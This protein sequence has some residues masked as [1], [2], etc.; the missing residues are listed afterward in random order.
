MLA[1]LLGEGLADDMV[2][3]TRR[4][5]SWQGS[6][7]FAAHNQGSPAFMP[8]SPRTSSDQTAVSRSVAGAS[9]LAP[10]ADGLFVH[11]GTA[12]RLP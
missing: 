1:P 2:T 9:A 6:P 4:V 10:Q 12:S 11:R 8:L 7:L 5:M 3:A